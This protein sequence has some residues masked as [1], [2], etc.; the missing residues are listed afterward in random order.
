MNEER[1]CNRRDFIRMAGAAALA[2]L[3]VPSCGGDGDS[4][5]G[6][7]DRADARTEPVRMTYRENRKGER[8]SL[9][10]FGMMRLPT[11]DKRAMQRGSTA[12]IDQKLVNSLVTEALDAGINYFDTSPRYAQGQSERA[13][14]IALK[15]FPRDR[16]NI[17]TKLSNFGKELW[18]RE[19]SIAMYENSFKELQ[20]E[21][22][23][24]M[25]LHA[26]GMGT[27]GMSTFRGRYIENG[28]L[29]FLLKQREQGRIRNLGF[30]YHG[31]V[32]V[33]DYVLAMGVD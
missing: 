23:N 4:A 1:K 8:I 3:S 24:Y 20:T 28:V 30:S 11:V 32:R 5:S 33:F 29:D 7:R 9:L 14:G 2:G 6:E 21:V 13:L 15:P 17:A 25:L 12:A 19:V 18:S 16:Y 27:D 31:E 10:G 26:V 22:I